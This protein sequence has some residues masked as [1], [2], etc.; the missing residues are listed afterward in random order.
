[1]MGK[2]TTTTMKIVAAI[3]IAAIIRPTAVVETVPAVRE[4][5]KIFR[6]RSIMAV[7][8]ETAIVAAR[9]FMRGNIANF[10]RRKK[11]IQINI[12]VTP[13]VGEKRKI[14]PIKT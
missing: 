11:Y 5:F 3:R 12:D 8:E 6:K 14:A 1:M 9:T 2:E 13:F 10:N 7:E 4:A